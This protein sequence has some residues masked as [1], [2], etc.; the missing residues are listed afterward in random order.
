[1]ENL[2][3][4]RDSLVSASQARM[5]EYENLKEQFEEVKKAMLSLV[6]MDAFQGRGA[7][8]IKGFYQAQSEVINAWLGLIDRQIAFLKGIDGDTEEAGLGGETTIYVPFLE[9]ELS[10]SIKQSKQMVH[11]QQDDISAILSSVSDLVDI[12]VYSTDRFEEAMENADKERKETIEAVEQLN[13]NLLNEYQQS[14]INQGFVVQLYSAL[15]DATTKGG[16]VSPIHFNLK[17]FKESDVYQ[18]RD[19]VQKATDEYVTL[20]DQ[21]AEYRQL[22]AAVEAEKNKPLYLKM[23][24]GFKNFTGEL[25]GYYDYKRATEGVDPITGRELSTAERVKAG[26]MALA[27]FI[28]IAGW[29]G[30]LGKGGL[31]ALKTFKGVSAATHALDAYKGAKSFDVLYKTEMGIYGLVTANGFGEY[32]TGQDMF[33]NPLTDAQRQD[34]LHGALLGLT[35]GTAAHSLNR[36]ASG[37]TLFPYSKAYVGQKVT[38]SQQALSKLRSNIGQLRVPVGVEAQQFA[39]STG[40]VTNLN[41]STK[42]LSDVK[43]QVMMKAE[44][45]GGKYK[46]KVSNRVSETNLRNIDHFINGNKK[47]D[48]VIEDYAIVYKEHIA[49]NKPWS[50]DDTIPGGDSLSPVQKRKVKELAIEKGHIPDIKVTKTVGMRYGFAD[51]ESAGIV[52]ETVH[53]PE[54]FWK[55]SDKEQFKWLDEQIG[56]TRRGRT[57]HHTE[58]PGKMELVP[59]GIHN[60][61]PHN[62]GRTKGMWADA[63]R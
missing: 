56:G 22:Q 14:E 13:Q 51:F 27:G 7:N 5:H 12:D 46:G 50:W 42:T 58:I 4:E 52:E 63:P 60:I 21:Q 55:L 53:L 49:L 8:A 39:T 45:V 54:R 28:P 31:G 15:I 41:L 37:Q 9:D 19:D 59:F 6:E 35:I 32:L 1:M 20:K 48:E 11:Q 3:Y 38:Q 25:T 30:R 17:A 43:Q 26:G 18:L 33:G 34:S 36:Q 40:R 44:G 24:D 62:G 23:V 2:I 10:K 16:N 47:F 57:W 29:G 61:T